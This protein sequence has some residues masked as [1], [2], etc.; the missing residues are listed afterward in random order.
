[1]TLTR[2]HYAYLAVI[3]ALL[4][5]M[6]WNHSQ[7]MYVRW[8]KESS[9]YSHGFMIPFVSVY[10]VWRMRESLLKLRAEPSR[11]GLP[12]LV[13]GALMRIGGAYSK[14]NVVAGFS[15]I[16]I[17]LGLTLFLFGRKITGKL[18]FPI[19]FLQLRAQDPGQRI[20]CPRD[21]VRWGRGQPVG[22]PAQLPASERR[23]R[24]PDC[25]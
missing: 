9:Y 21:A 8:F 16:V 15:L 2:S 17:L 4:A 12:V 3:G 1:M 10:L 13:F 23:S 18:L 22:Q 20:I 6:F 19:V 11:W 25:G 7:G 5:A 14:I 24:Q